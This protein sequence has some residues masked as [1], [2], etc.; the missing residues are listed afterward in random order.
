MTNK[1]GCI[2]CKYT[3][4]FI[5]IFTVEAEGIFF[6]NW[7]G[8]VSCIIK[9]L[10]NQ[11]TAQNRQAGFYF[12]T[13]TFAVFTLEILRSFSELTTPNTKRFCVWTSVCVCVLCLFRFSVNLTF[14]L[15]YQAG[16]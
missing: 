3:L 13:S 4:E 1:K 15:E 14:L 8:L 6:S 11:N 5:E 16:R 2:Y 7:R 12:F 9:Y 10:L